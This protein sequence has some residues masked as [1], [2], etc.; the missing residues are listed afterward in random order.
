MKSIMRITA[1][2]S[3]VA[4]GLA[5]ASTTFAAEK[6]EK[7][8]PASHDFTGVIESVDA[9]ANTVIV[10]KK[11]ESKTFS[12]TEKTKYATADKPEAALADL[13]QGDKVKVQFIEDG[14]K[15]VAKKIAVAAGKE[16]KEK[17]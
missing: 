7:A 17:K 2:V 5:F 11:D 1:M 14:G 10:K 16:K 9:T 8:K 6:A 3:V 12:V 15:T 13:K 4:V